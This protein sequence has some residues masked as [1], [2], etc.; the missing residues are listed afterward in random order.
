VNAVTEPGRALDEA[1][2][3][4]QRICENAPVSVQACLAAVNG[5]ARA[6]EDAGWA[7][8]GGAM[9]HLADSQDGTEGIR[10][11]LEKRRPVWTGR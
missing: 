8:T 7:A 4:A 1:V 3:L 2:A 11:F 5:L 6:D 10:A 9:A